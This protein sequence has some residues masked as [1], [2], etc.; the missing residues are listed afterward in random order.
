MSQNVINYD[1]IR[2]PWSSYDITK[3]MH[4]L[5][6]LPRSRQGQVN[7]Q[8]TAYGISPPEKY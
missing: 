2:K 8:L 6:S 7:E 5:I 3:N 1:E 4:Y